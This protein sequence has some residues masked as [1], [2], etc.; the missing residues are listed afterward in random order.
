MENPLLDKHPLFIIV[1]KVKNKPDD[2]NLSS[3]FITDKAE[4]RKEFLFIYLLTF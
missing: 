4:K 3:S 2:D 1:Y